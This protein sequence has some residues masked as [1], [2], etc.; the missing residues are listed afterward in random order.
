[1]ARAQ[2]RH[3][4]LPRELPDVVLHHGQAV[5]LLTELGFQ[6]RTS[7]STFK[8]Y[9]KSLRKFGT[10]F[11]ARTIGM[12][13]RGLANYKYHH[14]MELALV[15]TLRVYQV[16]PES[17]LTGIIRHRRSLHRLY[18]K[19]ICSGAPAAERRSL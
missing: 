3:R 8:E 17:I 6:G 14:L 19:R 4:N 7:K 5:W 10:P 15:L 13:R 9:I 1:L 16:G 12:A 11:E 18:R 2:L